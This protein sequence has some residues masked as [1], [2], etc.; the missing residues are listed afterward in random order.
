MASGTSKKTELKVI[1]VAWV[2]LEELLLG[3]K[4]VLRQKD[5]PLWGK[6]HP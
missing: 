4:D 6:D 2:S 5:L 3:F 1:G